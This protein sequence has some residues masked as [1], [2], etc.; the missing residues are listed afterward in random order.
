MITKISIFLLSPRI[1]IIFDKILF[2]A[3]I[4]CFCLLWMLI[5]KLMEAIDVIKKCTIFKMSN[6]S[7]FLLE[8]LIYYLSIYLIQVNRRRGGIIV[9]DM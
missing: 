3:K 9:F 6:T 1:N 7:I 8:G 2:F 4:I 5:K